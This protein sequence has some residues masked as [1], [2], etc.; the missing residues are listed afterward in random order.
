[1]MESHRLDLAGWA[2]TDRRL[3]TNG[4][5]LDMKLEQALT[6]MKEQVSALG[7]RTS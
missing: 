7:S 3:Q 2:E 5:E 1:M 6:E 4:N